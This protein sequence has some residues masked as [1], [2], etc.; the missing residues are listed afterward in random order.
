MA[1]FR[2]LPLGSWQVKVRRKGESAITNLFNTKALVKSGQVKKVGNGS[3][4][5]VTLIEVFDAKKLIDRQC[6]SIGKI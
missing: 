2:K 1:T 5:F 6:Y 3:R 4:Y